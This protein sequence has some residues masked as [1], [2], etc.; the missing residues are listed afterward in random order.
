MKTIVCV[1]QVPDST[2]VKY[3]IRT[4]RLENVN[5]I[6]DPIDEI[7][8]SEAIKIKERNG[9]EVTAV[10]LG[11]PRANA[12]MRSCLKMG[13]DSSIHLCDES[14]ESIDAYS[15]ADIL[16]RQITALQY[17]LILCGNQSMDEGNGFVGAGIAGRLN[18][19]LVTAVTRIDIFTDTMTAVV[20]RRL[21]GGDR[22]IIE[23]PLPAVFT[24]ESVL[25]SP[26]YP[27]LRVI[28]SGL[29]KDVATVDV[30]SLGIDPL[31]MEQALSLIN[32]SQPKPRLKKT[33]T[34]DSSLTAQERMRL[35]MTG[36]MQKKSSNVIQKLPGAA[37]ADIIQFLID[38]GI[39]SRQR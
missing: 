37:A 19:P 1:K 20:H 23:T 3:D 6:M 17:D 2:V 21:K 24:V 14:F 5:Y 33:A 34:I 18:L 13:V 10:T 26:I 28:L 35:L 4:N 11:P 31:T 39:I 38:N 25:T 12:V 30:R 27:R 22:E 16:S 15:T 7:S 36:G 29:K 9:G 32:L 8:I